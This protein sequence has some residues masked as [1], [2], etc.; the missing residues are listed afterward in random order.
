M[1]TIITYDEVAALVANLPSIAPR[2]NFTNLCNLWRHIQHALKRLRCPQSNILGWV[3][4]IMSGAMY[5]LLT[6][7]PFQLPL[8]PRPEAIYYGPKIPIAYAQ[9]DPVL[10]WTWDAD[11]S[12][13]ANHRSC[14]TSH[15]RHTC[16]RCKKL[17][18][19]VYEHSQ[20]GVQLPRQWDQWCIQGIKWSG[21][22]WMEP[23][24]G[25]KGNLQPN[26]GNI[27]TTHTCSPP[28]KWYFVLECIFPSRC[29]W[30]P[31]STHRRLW[32]SSDS[33]QR[34]FL[35]NVVWLL[36]QCGCILAISTTGIASLPPKRFGPT[37]KHSSKNVTHFDWTQPASR[38][39]CKDTSKTPLPP[40]GRN[41][42][43][44]MTTSKLSSCK[45]QR[46]LNKV[47]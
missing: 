14:W 1:D 27:W 22:C 41:P 44:K 8:D 12:S 5:G 15:H 29:P 28:T 24:N 7:T 13:P 43:M 42:K 17:I 21:A 19:I 38:Q 2:P 40:S 35:N 10:K 31:F 36:L 30:S 33:R 6:M 32:R 37:S 25:T 20:G 23:V 34:S 45:W 16:Q 3:G 11:I 18:W 26:H 46:W 4:L 39:D 9:W 47:N